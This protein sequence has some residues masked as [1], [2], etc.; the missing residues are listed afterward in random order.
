MRQPAM[1]RKAR[2]RI[3]PVLCASS[4][5]QTPIHFVAPHLTR[6]RTTAQTAC[7]LP[8]HFVKTRTSTITIFHASSSSAKRIHLFGVRSGRGAPGS[9]WMATASGCCRSPALRALQE[10]R[11]ILKTLY[12]KKLFPSAKIL[13]ATAAGLWLYFWCFEKRTIW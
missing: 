1:L 10:A 4:G 5:C 12:L 9:L 11:Q 2:R 8:P 13:K 6:S 7:A 3:K